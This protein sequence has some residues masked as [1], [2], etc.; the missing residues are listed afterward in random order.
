MKI[1]AGFKNSKNSIKKISYFLRGK[2]ISRI[3]EK[4]FVAKP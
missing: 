2:R 3:C 4:K 1:L